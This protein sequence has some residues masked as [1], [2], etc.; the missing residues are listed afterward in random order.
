M[1]EV[2]SLNTACR[3]GK[4]PELRNPGVGLSI[5]AM[6]L[7]GALAFGASAPATAATE[8]VGLVKVVKGEAFGT[9]PRTAREK[10]FRRFPIVQ[11]ELLETESG[12]GMLVEFLDETTLTLGDD[13]SL[14]IDTFV[15][16]PATAN[17][18]TLL[19]FAVGTLRFISGKGD[20]AALQIDT[21]TAIIAIR[22]SDAII[23]VA[24]DGATTVA[25]LDGEFEVSNSD[26]DEQATV[27]PA[28]SVSVSATGSV[29]TVAPGPTEPPAELDIAAPS[30]SI[31][32]DHGLSDTFDDPG[33]SEGGEDSAGSG[34]SDEGD[35]CFA[36]G[37]LVRMA[38]GTFK[39]IERLIVG[40]SVM[41][42]D[43][44]ADRQ[45]AATVT[46]VYRKTVDSYLH[47]NDLVVT[48][49]HP[50]VVGPGEWRVA[51]NLREGDR[52]IGNSFTT[53]DRTEQVSQ[54]VSVFNLI[55]GWPHTFYVH[56]G[57]NLYLVSNKH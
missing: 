16:D 41:A 52:V 18:T 3:T 13:T 43:F 22:G 51:A 30:A 39:P 20:F 47:L 21:P 31:D 49:N 46:Q 11:D 1:L 24:P 53:I 15:Y 14:V 28:G 33:G 38:D 26:G 5:T 54:S 12:A 34:S 48:A 45:H 35:S 9:P 29:G 40:D 42:Y 8:L 19:S 7:A 2:D 10:K 57:Q 23:S 55:V 4:E 44:P 36:A 17:V 50:F 56:D 27:G 37:T 32:P 6:V 25:V